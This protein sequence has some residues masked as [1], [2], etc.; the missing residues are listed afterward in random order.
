MQARH[1][2][3]GGIIALEKPSMLVYIDR[4]Y[5]AN[6]G[7]EPSGLWQRSTPFLSAPTE[8]HL[9]ITNR[10]P[11]NC[12]ECYVGAGNELPGE[13]TTPELKRVIDL[14][15]RMKVFHI[16]FGGGEPFAR[17]DFLE[18]ASYAR[19]KGIVPNVTT[20]GFYITEDVAKRCG[21]FGQIN[22]S[23]DGLDGGYTN[24]RGFEG[25]HIADR[26][27]KLLR[28]YNRNV[29]INCVVSKNNFDQLEDIVRY[30]KRNRV[31][32][33]LFLRYKPSGRAKNNYSANRLTHKQYK[34]I[35]PLLMRL[36]KRHWINLQADCSFVPMVCYHRPSKKVMDFFGLQG[37]VAGN[38]LAGV[39]ADGRFN[40]CSFSPD[41]GGSVFNLSE[42]WERSSHLN[43]YRDWIDSA[44]EPCR[45]CDYLYLCKGGCH[46]VSDFVESN[47]YQPDPECPIVVEY[48]H[49]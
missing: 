34:E 37:C 20:N 40:A 8:V 21:I 35:Y 9:S 5:M 1:E 43:K 24:S 15:S 29:G 36:M 39:L 23:L 10:C 30:A 17:E 16:A 18:L 33:I 44:P 38:I 11:M 45:S 42:E 26:A 46:I 12:K 31:N 6:L 22:V 19:E 13:L 32:S 25:F 41:D 27:I 28:R 14:L 47:F 49:D 7:Y 4:D 48:N 3:F 2:S